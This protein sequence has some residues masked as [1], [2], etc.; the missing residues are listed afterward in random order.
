MEKNGQDKK[1]NTEGL[2]LSDYKNLDGWSAYIQEFFG[3]DAAIAFA[4]GSDI[5]LNFLEEDLEEL[6]QLSANSH[7][8]QLSCSLIKDRLPKQFLM[9]YTYEFLLKVK[10]SLIQLYMRAKAG[11]PMEPSS[12]IE[13][14]LI[15]I[16]VEI[17]E[18]DVAF[19]E[20]KIYT[21]NK[22][23]I[24]DLFGDSDM[25]DLLYSGFLVDQNNDYHIDY[26]FKKWF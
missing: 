8:G 16:C 2:N 7:L 3:T 19:N 22:E 4:A 1:M 24:Y 14:I 13:E 20:A 17:G 10:Q 9:N 5:F 26:W 6:S 23:W 12:V 15:K 25:E 21:Y 11:L 18:C